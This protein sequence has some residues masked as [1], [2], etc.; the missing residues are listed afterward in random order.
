M[1]Y[2]LMIL[3]F[4]VV[5]VLG[6]NQNIWAQSI[7]TAF[8]YQG[9]LM[10][11]GEVA[12]G[13]YDFEFDLFDHATSG[14]VV[15]TTVVKENVGVYDG[16]FTVE[17]DF[18]SV[19]NGNKRWLAVGVRP[20]ELADP[21]VYTP[22]SPRQELTVAPYSL[23]AK[24]A[25]AVVGGTG[26]HGSG[27]AN[28]IPKFTSST[29]IG[30]S[31]IYETGGKIGIGTT[32]PFVKLSVVGDIGGIMS[33]GGGVGVGGRGDEGGV[34]GYS[35]QGYGVKG[36]TDSGYAGY[37]E[38]HVKIY[39]ARTGYNAQLEIPGMISYPWPSGGYNVK[40]VNGTLFYETSSARYKDNIQLFR[41]DFS[42]IL[43]AQPKSYTC[44]T[45]GR[46]EIGFIAEEFDELGLNELVIY[47]QQGRP[48]GLAYPMVSLYLL[49]VLKDE[50]ESGREQEE[51]INKLEQKNQKLE[52]RL[53][54]LER[55]MGR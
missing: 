4:V 45:T 31:V 3:L 32:S 33:W 53:D 36:S 42:K 1:M 25:E 19:F 26:V 23:F 12:N 50:V 7:G 8:T 29:T 35:S 28:Y 39:D 22:L 24:T 52:E 2:K 13:F 44:K 11:G 54:A 37:F 20:G 34:Y 41:E 6:L 30:D 5:V 55:M 47:D 38:G 9:K 14:G 16:Y 27:T 48:D 46:T 40:I 21:N 18:G 17:L 15:S 10:D 43:Q 49:E 51:T